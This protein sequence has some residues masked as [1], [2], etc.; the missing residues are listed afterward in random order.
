MTLVSIVT[1]TMP[2]REQLL[3]DRCLP[4]VAAQHW[5]DVEHVIVSDPNPELRE[6]IEAEDAPNYLRFVELNDTWRDG[7]RERSVGAV[8][9]YVG[10][11]LA[12]GEYV[13]FLG[14][15]DELLPDHVARHVAALRATGAG[16]TIS[17]V[18]F[19]VRGVDRF[20]IGDDTFAHGHLDSD[21]I[22]C[23]RDSLRVATWT[24]TGEDAADYRL[25]RDWLNS[26][27]SGHFLGGAPTAVHHDG[28]AAR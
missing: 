23:P 1:P 28:W 17:P 3:L 11:L 14:D 9:W 4:S 15:D 26:G 8:P 21:G 12:Q 2:G 16:F 25:V 22:M 18:Q 13:G 27:L 10:S 19:R 20:V 6:L 7:N 24:A 5:P